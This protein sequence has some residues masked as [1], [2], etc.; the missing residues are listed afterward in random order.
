MNHTF[1]YSS[2]IRFKLIVTVYCK[3][4]IVFILENGTNALVIPSSGTSLFVEIIIGS[5]VIPPDNDKLP[6]IWE[7]VVCV[8][9]KNHYGIILFHLILLSIN[10]SPSVVSS[11]TK[12]Q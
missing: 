8:F 5:F 11:T 6:V 9:F 4:T 7:P 12:N 1:L 10:G 2:I 3:L